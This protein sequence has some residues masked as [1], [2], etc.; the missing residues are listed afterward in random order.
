VEQPRHQTDA[1]VKSILPA[2]KTFPTND[3][4]IIGCHALNLSRR[5]CEYDLLVVSRD[6]IPDKFTKVADVY[7][8]IIFRNERE[9]RQPDPELAVTLASAVPLRDSSLLLATATSDCKRSFT[10][11]C[12]KAAEIHLASSLKSLARVEELLSQNETSEADFS[13]LSAAR[14]FAWAD[15][16]MSGVIPSPSHVLGQVKALPK[17]RPSSFKVWAD[18]SGLE[19]ASRVSC[20]NRL[21]GLSVIYDVLRTS[22]AGAEKASQLGRYREVEAV[23]VMEMKAAELLDSMQSAECFSY[24]GQES[25]QSLFDLYVLH[26]TTLSKEKDYSRVIRDLTDGEDRLLSKEVVKLLGLV[27]GPEIIRSATPGLRTAVSLL[28]KRI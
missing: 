15:L 17:K 23:E 1:S 18:A 4:A 14:D 11:N 22:G 24:L 20:E 7:A 19:L 27:R 5:S 9:V 8:R 13:L 3:V 21:E 2:L 6:P 16:L 25:V 12:K 26:V 10:A 28:A